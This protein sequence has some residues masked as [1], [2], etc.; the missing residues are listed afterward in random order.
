LQDELAQ[1]AGVGI[2]SVHRG[3]SGLPLRLDIVRKL[4]VALEV[5]PA[6]LMAQPPAED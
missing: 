6:A 1:L 3:E 4:A 5:D 2:M